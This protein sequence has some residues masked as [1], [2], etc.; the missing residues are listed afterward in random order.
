MTKDEIQEDEHLLDVILRDSI[1]DN[2]TRW[3]V[4]HRTIAEVIKP[5]VDNVKS[6]CVPFM[7]LDPKS[8]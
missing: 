6:D 1:P 3:Y 4:I 7:Y 2:G 5:R 8:E